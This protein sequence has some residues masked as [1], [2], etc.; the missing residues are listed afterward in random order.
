MNGDDTRQHLA[1][2]SP[3]YTAAILLISGHI[4]LAMAP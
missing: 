1:P 2:L 4:R 3:G